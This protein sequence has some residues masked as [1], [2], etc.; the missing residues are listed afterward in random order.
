MATIT[1]YKQD[2]EG[3]FIEK[4]RLAE[5]TYS[6]DWSQW[7]A[8]GQD[9]V[10]VAYSIASPTYNPVPLTIITSGIVN[11]YVTFVK[12]AGGTAGKI[13]TVTAQITTDDASVDRRSFRI[14][15]ENR[16]L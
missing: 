12:L 11:D 13:Y 3:A 1:G 4:D 5:L 9:L 2:T 6:M 10:A 16:S 14:V 8:P 7:A 15:V